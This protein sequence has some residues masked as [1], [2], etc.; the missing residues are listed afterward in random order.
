[1]SAFLGPIHY[2]LF[3]KIKFENDL[4]QNIIEFAKE[5]DYGLEAVKSVDEVCGVLENGNLEDLID[6]MNIHGW[7]QERVNV[8][9]ERLAF[10]TTA[11]LSEDENRLSEILK[12]AFDFGKKNA[13]SGDSIEEAYASFNNLMLNGMPCD[14]VIEIVEESE[15]NI[16][17]VQT[18]DIH[19]KYWTK[20]M[21]DVKNY[22]AIRKSVM[23]GIFDGGKIEFKPIEGK[24]SFELRRRV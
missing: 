10:I 17:L 6:G 23:A 5:K 9:E 19:E 24:P 11:I 22:Y 3:T 15:D 20:F 12:V 4:T 21:G 13:Y 16:V 2:W 1:M 8:V 14:R 18:E 7:L